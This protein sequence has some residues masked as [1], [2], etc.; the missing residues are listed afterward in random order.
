MRVKTPLPSYLKKKSPSAQTPGESGY[1]PHWMIGGPM[2]RIHSPRQPLCGA[3]G[4]PHGGLHVYL[5]EGDT[6][7]RVEG[8]LLSGTTSWY[9]L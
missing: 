9:T 7:S 2:D 4:I 3:C 5:L 6:S 8:A 1:F